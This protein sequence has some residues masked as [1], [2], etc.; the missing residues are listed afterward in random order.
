MRKE[1]LQK[2]IDDH[3]AWLNNPLKGACASLRRLSLCNC[4][5]QDLDLRYA[6]FTMTNMYGADLKRT[7]LVGACFFEASLCE[8]DLRHADLRDADLRNAD[9]RG[10]DLTGATL[11]GAKLEG[12]RGLPPIACPETGGFTAYKR[13]EKYNKDTASTTYFIAELYIP[14]NAKRSSATTRKC[15]CSRAKVIRFWNFDRT[16]ADIE[17]AY[18]SHNPT[19]RYL[20]GE[21]VTPRYSFDENRWNEC[22]SGI[23]FFLT[24]NE[25][26]DYYL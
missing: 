10:A 3:N 12:T 16:I 19:F 22:T 1:S 25:A 6:D 5:L 26:R 11:C 2:I 24:F 7:R 18:S 13:V 23:H 8:A 14:A 15:R 20:K 17:Y 4:D 9:L 21:Y